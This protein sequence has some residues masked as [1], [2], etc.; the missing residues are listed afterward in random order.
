[1]N[2]F[3]FKDPR[4]RRAGNGIL[5]SLEGPEL[6]DVDKD[7]VDMILR[8][9]APVG[10]TAIYTVN[11][12]RVRA[13][14]NSWAVRGIP[15]DSITLQPELAKLS[16]ILMQS[17]C[18]RPSKMPQRALQVESLEK[19][20]CLGFSQTIGRVSTTIRCPS[21]GKKPSWVKV[22]MEARG[23]GD[24]RIFEYMQVRALFRVSFTWRRTA[25]A[26]Q[27]QAE[28]LYI[29]GRWARVLD[30]PCDFTKATVLEWDVEDSDLCLP[31]EQFPDRPRYTFVPDDAVLE[32]FSVLP[33]PS[34]PVVADKG[35]IDDGSRRMW[36]HEFG[37]S[38]VG[39]R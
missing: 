17:H 21:S 30:E 22:K 4:G 8:V 18:F 7:E 27:K 9:A 13:G 36:V 29:M 34:H 33:M 25:T 15:T 10:A 32:D 1:M 14:V 3:K 38:A 31:L 23:D 5:S 28:H 37:K 16:K 26:E 24:T 11:V 2:D 35:C 20:A 12:F 39:E 6:C 19:L